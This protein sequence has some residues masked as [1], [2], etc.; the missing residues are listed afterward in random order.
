MIHR[1]ASKWRRYTSGA[2]VAAFITLVTVLAVAQPASAVGAHG[3]V[4][5][6]SDPTAYVDPMIGT[7]NGGQVVGDINDFPGVDA[8]PPLTEY[9]AWA[10]FCNSAACA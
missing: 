10:L 7:G 3:T 8:P 5:T 6:V 4:P 9:A 1:Q 2:A